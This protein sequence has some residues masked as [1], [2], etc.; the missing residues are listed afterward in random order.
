MYKY[1]MERLETAHLEPKIDKLVFIPAEAV[2][3]EYPSDDFED[4]MECNTEDILETLH[5]DTTDKIRENIDSFVQEKMLAFLMATHQRAGF[6]AEVS[7]DQPHDFSFDESGEAC[8]WVSGGFY[9]LRWIYADSIGELIE[10][11][12]KEADALFAT[13]VKK[14]KAEA[15]NKISNISGSDTDGLQN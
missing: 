1:L 8:S 4:F 6:L 3:G 9:Y 14:A 5:W 15:E 13:A 2:R 10:N 11:I 12:I 7:F